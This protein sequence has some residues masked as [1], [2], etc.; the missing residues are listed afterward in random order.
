MQDVLLTAAHQYDIE[1]IKTICASSPY[2]HK[3]CTT[4]AFWKPVFDHYQFTLPTVIPSTYGGWLRLFYRQYNIQLNIQYIMDALHNRSNAGIRLTPKFELDIHIVINL[5]QFYKFYATKLL[6]IKNYPLDEITIITMD[7]DYI[8]VS[9]MNQALEFNNYIGFLGDF[10][11]F[12]AAVLEYGF[13]I[14][15]IML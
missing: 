9:V 14:E 10:E 8:Q 4:L 2:L 15:V 7:D 12:L 11:M 3:Q 1:N 6:N 5:L 13:H